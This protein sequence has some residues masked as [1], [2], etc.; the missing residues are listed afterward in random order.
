MGHLSYDSTAG[1]LSFEII[2]A[3]AAAILVFIIAFV[4]LLFAYRR[5]TTRHTRQMKNLKSQM[6]NIEMKVCKFHHNSL[7]HWTV[8]DLQVAAECKEAFAELQTSMSAM[9]ADAPIGAPIIPYLDYRE[10]ATQVRKQW[11]QCTYRR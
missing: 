5:K 6:D 3:I 1:P 2:V 4:L 11:H 7:T 9:A 10:Y 8:R